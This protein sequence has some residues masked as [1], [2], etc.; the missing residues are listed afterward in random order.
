MQTLGLCAYIPGADAIDYNLTPLFKE[1]SIGPLVKRILARKLAR[2]G[3][4]EPEPNDP[5]TRTFYEQCFHFG[6]HHT[7]GIS[8][9]QFQDWLEG[10]SVEVEAPPVLK[11]PNAMV[12]VSASLLAALAA[13]PFVIIAGTTG[14]GKTQ[15]I[16]SCVK[17]LCP[18]DTEPASTTS[19]S[20]SKPDGQIV[21]IYS[22]T[23]IHLDEWVK[24]T[25]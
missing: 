7:L 19:S 21:G 3:W 8:E 9:R 17:A 4:K 18:T 25:V 11:L 2:T 14:T 1:L 6:F 23:V 12:T 5:F 24:A 15:T 13:K 22:D 20:P 16:R 10:Q